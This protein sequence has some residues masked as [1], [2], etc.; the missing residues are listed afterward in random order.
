[1]HQDDPCQGLDDP[2]PERSHRIGQEARERGRVRPG[3]LHHD[4]EAVGRVEGVGV[5]EQEPVAPGE[6][7]NVQGVSLAG[8]AGRQ[9]GRS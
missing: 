6:P 8:P 4:R 9:I 2:L 3:E 5:E 7:A 1:M